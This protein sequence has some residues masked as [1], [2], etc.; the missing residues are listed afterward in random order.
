MADLHLGKAQTFLKNGF[1]LPPQAHVEDL[2]ILSE[3]MKTMDVN[4][5]LFLGDFIHS[6]EGVT[7]DVVDE[8]L[9][10]RKT[11]LGEVSVVIG[12][13]DRPFLSKWPVPWD[14]INLTESIKI[15]DFIFQHEPPKEV[16]ENDFVWCG[17]IHPKIKISKGPDQLNLPA[18]VI[19]PQVGYLPAFT[20]L[21]AGMNFKGK[22]G[23]RYFVAADSQR[24]IEIKL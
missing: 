5:V 10:W 3:I 22:K 4:H 6:S 13:H 17:H 24:V 21:A 2:N 14:F 15:K 11:F 19:E 7:S 20:S 16:L 18:F 1:W 23:S 12:N 9:E 8:F